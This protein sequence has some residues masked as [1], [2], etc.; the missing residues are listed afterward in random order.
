[1]TDARSPE[2]REALADMLAMCQLIADTVSDMTSNLRAERD[3]LAAEVSE[4]THEA[5]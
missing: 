1:M 3:R 4:M 5:A 2:Y